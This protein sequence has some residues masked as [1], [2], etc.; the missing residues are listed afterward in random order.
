M[1][2]V[3]TLEQVKE[4]F[5]NF[6]M[7]PK[8]NTNSRSFSIAT[9]KKRERINVYYS[10]NCMLTLDLPL[11]IKNNGGAREFVNLNSKL[12]GPGRFIQKQYNSFGIRADVIDTGKSS[13][14][15]DAIKA[16]LDSIEKARALCK[17]LNGKGAVRSPLTPAHRDNIRALCAEAEWDFID[18]NERCAIRLKVP[19]R[20]YHADVEIVKPGG[21]CIK[22]MIAAVTNWESISKDGLSNML[23]SVCNRIKMIRASRFV[24]V[25]GA[26][27]V[28]L[29]SYLG[30]NVSVLEIDLALSSL[31]VACRTVS[32]EVEVMRSGKV[33][34]EYLAFISWPLVKKKISKERRKES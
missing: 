17:G 15:S 33:A 13:E 31:S 26:E 30:Q 27:H 24:L 7:S 3:I 5:E 22:V 20:I 1:T 4:Q 21:Y 32:D 25:D 28:F 19:G 23:L 18:R 9:G 6:G 8:Q 16:A 10:D 14:F 34:G 11:S 29:E 2:P 12:H